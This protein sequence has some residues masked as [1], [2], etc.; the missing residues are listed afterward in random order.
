MTIEKCLSDVY[1]DEYG[2]HS[3]NKENSDGDSQIVADV[4][5][6]GRIQ[7]ELP[8]YDSACKFQDEVGKFIVEAIREKIA[9]I[10]SQTEISDEE[11][12]KI[13]NPNKLEKIPES[14]KSFIDG[15]KW[16]REQLKQKQ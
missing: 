4:R 13:I 10:S 9:R 12:E 11:I 7:N 15:A 1:Y 2:T 14:W 3:W 16:Y 5:G 6:W 8:D